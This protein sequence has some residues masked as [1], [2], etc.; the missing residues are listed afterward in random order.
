[1]VEERA[2]GRGESGGVNSPGFY[3]F[4]ASRCQAGLSTQKTHP[5]AELPASIQITSLS[6]HYHFEYIT[7]IGTKKMHRAVH[8]VHFLIM[9]ETDDG[10]SYLFS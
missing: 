2:E 3:C 8:S 6:G 9:A 10:P 7:G 4:T 5:A 1:M